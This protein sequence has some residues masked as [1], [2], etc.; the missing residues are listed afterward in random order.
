MLLYHGSSTSDLKTLNPFTADH[1]KP[2]V[3]FSTD[4]VSAGFHAVSLV[5]RPFYWFPYGYDASGKP[6]YSEVYPN[7]FA[8]AY[9]NKAGFIYVCDIE[10][11]RLLRFPSNQNTRL[12]TEPVAVSRIERIDNLYA[13]FLQREHD[14]KLVIQRFSELTTDALSLWHGMVLEE[15][16]SACSKGT[17]QNA[18]ARF[19]QQK[20]PTVWERYLRESD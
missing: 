19:V 10:D 5:E 2:Y 9:Q 13:W 20:M 11:K 6:F 16:R 8:D 4:A 3:Y 7:A 15:L 12:S 18:Y 14:G 17:T 1:G